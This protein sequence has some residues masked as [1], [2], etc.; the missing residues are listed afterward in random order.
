MKSVFVPIS[1]I[2]LAPLECGECGIVFAVPSDWKQ[3]RMLGTGNVGR[4]YVCPNGHRRAWIS[5]TEAERL[6]RELAATKEQLWAEQRERIKM[7][8]HAHAGLC[9]YCQ[10]NFVN[11]G[12]H[13][14]HKHPDKTADPLF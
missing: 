6:R 4:E 8:K 10:R 5:E 9:P 7:A 3:Q 1:D 13:V 14:R 2:E 11:L 12:K